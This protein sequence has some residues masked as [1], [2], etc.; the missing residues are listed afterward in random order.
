MAQVCPDQTPQE[1]FVAQSITADGEL[2]TSRQIVYHGGRD[3]VKFGQFGPRLYRFRTCLR[4]ELSIF[5]LE[6]SFVPLKEI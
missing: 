3:G 6:M 1:S 2:E 4:S 5:Q